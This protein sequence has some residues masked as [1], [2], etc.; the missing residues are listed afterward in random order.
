M[1]FRLITE[2]TKRKWATTEQWD[3]RLLLNN[4]KGATIWVSNSQSPFDTRSEALAHARL[5]LLPQVHSLL[6]AVGISYEIITH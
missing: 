3:S 1:T 4:A 6:T 5:M 2:A